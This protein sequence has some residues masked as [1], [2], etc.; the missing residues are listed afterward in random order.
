[1]ET[2]NTNTVK[3]TWSIL[4]QNQPFFQCK[5]TILSFFPLLVNIFIGHFLDRL[6]LN[7][8]LKSCHVGMN[9]PSAPNHLCCSVYSERGLLLAPYLLLGAKGCQHLHPLAPYHLRGLTLWSA[10]CPSLNSD[11][12]YSK[13]DHVVITWSPSGYTPVW[14]DCPETLSSPYLLI[15]TWQLVKAHGVT[16]NELKIHFICYITVCISGLIIGWPFQ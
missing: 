5:I 16:W 13:S 7:S 15:T 14:P 3:F 1:M 6:G 11:S 9:W 8:G 12:L 10:A 2:Q 4:Q